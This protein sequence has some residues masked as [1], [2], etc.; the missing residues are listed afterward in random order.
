MGRTTLKWEELIPIA[1]KIRIES[2]GR[3]PWNYV[4]PLEKNLKIKILKGE[5]IDRF[6]AEVEK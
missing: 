2:K 3:L 6:I 5:E 4:S 1:E